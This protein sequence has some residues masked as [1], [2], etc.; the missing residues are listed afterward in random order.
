M[1][2]VTDRAAIRDHIIDIARA[3]PRL[4]SGGRAERSRPGRPLGGTAT[5]GD[6]L[7]I[8]RTGLYAAAAFVRYADSERR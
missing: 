5:F 1:F 4:P 2:S 7:L 8:S 6:A 3:D